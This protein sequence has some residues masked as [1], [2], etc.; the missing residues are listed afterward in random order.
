MSTISFQDHLTIPD[1]IARDVDSFRRWILSG[2]APD[3][4]RFAF[5][6]Q[7]LWVDPATEE[8]FTHNLVKA[9][10]GSVLTRITKE[11][12]SGFYYVDGMLL[13]DSES[14]LSTEPDGFFV[15]FEGIRAG[16]VRLLPDESG[17]VLEVLG[18]PDMALEIVSRTS[19]RKDTVILRDLYHRTGVREYWLVDARQSPASFQILRITVQGYVAVGPVDGWLRSDVFD[20]EFRLDESVDPLGHVEFTL[21]VKAN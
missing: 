1:W 13:S 5:L 20:R 9:E 3:D 12:R 4:A 15:S 7:E 14:S 8:S 18:S 6:G 16:R 10:Y 19:V 21:A 11:A 17:G 2:D